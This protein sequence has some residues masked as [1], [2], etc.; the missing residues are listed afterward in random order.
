MIFIKRVVCFLSPSLGKGIQKTQSWI[1]ITYNHN[2]W[3]ILFITCYGRIS[4]IRGIHWLLA[5]TVFIP[6]H[7]NHSFADILFEKKKVWLLCKQR[8]NIAF[9][10][11]EPSVSYTAIMRAYYIHRNGSLDNNFE[12]KLFQ[13][14]W[15][16]SSAYLTAYITWY[17]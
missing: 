3:E 14:S 2:P 11:T 9:I 7:A 15:D 6:A 1:K 17:C 16:L 10:I 13:T 8:G 12:R 4:W 5:F